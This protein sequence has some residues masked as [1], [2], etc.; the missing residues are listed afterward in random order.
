MGRSTRDQNIK[1]KRRIIPC[2]EHG[3]SSLY[4]REFVGHHTDFPLSSNGRFRGEAGYHVTGYPYEVW[5][6]CTEPECLYT[7]KLRK[8]SQVT[9]A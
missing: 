9:D 3:Y 6:L 5:V 2:L 4:L 8:C 1:L 7:Y